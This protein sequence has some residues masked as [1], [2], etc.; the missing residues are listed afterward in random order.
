[1]DTDPSKYLSHILSSSPD[2][3]LTPNG[4]ISTTTLQPYPEQPSKHCFNPPKDK[5]SKRFHAQNL[6]LPSRR[7]QGGGNPSTT[8][9]KANTSHKCVPATTRPAG[10]GPRRQYVPVAACSGS[11]RASDPGNR[12]P[13]FC[14]SGLF[15]QR[16]CVGKRQKPTGNRPT[17]LEPH[18]PSL[19]LDWMPGWISLILGLRRGT[20]LL[21]RPDEI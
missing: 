9:G 5:V 16:R 8:R 3:L 1:V 7:S 20:F 21:S 18:P 12:H 17:L 4:Q 13:C 15:V 6:R 19:R 11:G 14:Q 2:E 10:A